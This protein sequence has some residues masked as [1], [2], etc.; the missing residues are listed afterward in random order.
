VGITATV[1]QGKLILLGCLAV[2]VWSRT[3]Q[4][5][6][7]T[8]QLRPQAGLYLPT[9]ISIQNGMLHVRQKIGMTVGAR[10]TVVFNQRLDVVTG[11]T[12]IPGYAV[13]RG[14]GKRVVVG[15]SS[16][17]LTATTAA[18]Y[19]LLPATRRLSWQVHTGLGVWAGGQ[20]AYKDLFEGSTLS[21]IL[22]TTVRYQ[23]GQIVSLQLRIQ[24]RLFRVRLG[25]RSP[26]NS[27]SPLKVSL[28]LGFPFLDLAQNR[29]PDETFEGPPILKGHA[30]GT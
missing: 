27:R 11:V 22:G 29:E 8:V 19:S 21:G 10:L 2:V 6:A 7:Q 24:E 18:R 26:D 5:N 20:R 1:H 16:H 25:G 13:L 15:T 23:I 28:V 4:L 12:Y 17:L 9:R 3:S 30:L 14:A